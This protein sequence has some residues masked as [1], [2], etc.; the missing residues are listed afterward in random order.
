MSGLDHGPLAGCTYR[1]CGVKGDEANCLFTKDL[2]A[3]PQPNWQASCNHE[4]RYIGMGSFYC[5]YCLDIQK[6]PIRP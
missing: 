5:V 1:Q 4:Y 6:K 2:A 3:E